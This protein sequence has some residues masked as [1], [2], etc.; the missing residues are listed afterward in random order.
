MG[1]L[2]SVV[3]M[4]ICLLKGEIRVK[5]LHVFLKMVWSQPFLGT[6]STLVNITKKL[7]VVLGVE[8]WLALLGTH[9]IPFR[10]IR[11]CIVVEGFWGNSLRLV[12]SIH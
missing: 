11:T 7:R 12:K 3:V 4:I 2:E 10:L 6:I 8:G 5:H 9:G 1:L